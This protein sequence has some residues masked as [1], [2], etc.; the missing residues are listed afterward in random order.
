M[1]VHPYHTLFWSIVGFLAGVMA[2]SIGLHI[3]VV[4]LVLGSEIIFLVL[5][6]TYPTLR[7]YVRSAAL[8]AP[9]V[10]VGFVYY[11]TDDALFRRER[12]PFGETILIH[13]TVNSV[14]QVRGGG[15]D[16]TVSVHEPFRAR[17]RI[18]TERYPT[19][20]YGDTI[21]FRGA[22]EESADDSFGMY[23]QKERIRGTV[24]F[25]EVENI[26]HGTVRQFR[27]VLLS[28]RST[29]EQ[30]LMEQFSPDVAGFLSGITL[31]GSHALSD[32]MREVM[33]KTGTTH[34][35]ALSGYNIS[36][37]ALSL[38]ALFGAIL[39]RRYALILTVIGIIVFVM[40]AGGEASAVRAAIMG[41][42]IIIA[43][44]F[45]RA[46]DVRNALALAAFAMVLLNP[47]VLAF[48]IGFQLS[49][50]AL[51]GIVYVKPAFEALFR[52][53]T[54]TKGLLAWREGALTT[55]AAQVAVLPLLLITFGN[56]PAISLVANVAIL[57]L[58]P[59]TMLLG[60]LFVLC[61]FVFDPL[62]TIIAY[63][64][65]L[66]IGMELGVLRWFS[67]FPLA[68][69]LSIS[70]PFLVAYYTA[71]GFFIR[72]GINRTSLSS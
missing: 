56:V 43:E 25:P 16:S 59:I 26:E 4:W 67:R 57:W 13:G 49:F 3:S 55:A 46:Y 21:T 52:I 54:N 66:L 38:L 30:R 40:F 11:Y 64:V 68:L 69:T 58:I 5:Y 62:A 34:L 71:L 70:T 28:L 61:S 36:V 7:V 12:I 47:K 22:I 19:I 33:Q 50:L 42:I 10:L 60:F 63:G 15:Q 39:K 44:A 20:T 37:I 41:I 6:F 35:V 31:G 9:L 14:P 32:T 29:V 18:R 72:Y 27:G 2:A 45:G 24:S 65:H 17:I 51:I 23:L 8:I 53:Q 48:D 1:L